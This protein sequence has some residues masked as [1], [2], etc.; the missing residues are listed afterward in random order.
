MDITQF[1]LAIIIGTVLSLLLEEIAGI[2]CGGIIVPGYLAMVCDDIPTIL[3]TVFISF[4]CYFIV[5]FGLSKVMIL[6]GKRKFAITIVIALILNIILKILFPLFNALPF[7]TITFRGI[8]A[9]TPALLANT[10]SRQ[11]FRYTIPA[12]IVVTGVTWGLVTLI[13]TVIR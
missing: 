1:Y 9:V 8:G 5:N 13:C 6:Y 2:S 3:I 12:C 7:E 10:Y 4:A 11:A